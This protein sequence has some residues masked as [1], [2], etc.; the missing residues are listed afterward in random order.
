MSLLDA[1][2]RLKENPLEFVFMSSPQSVQT[3]S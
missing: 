1:E 2:R 3:E